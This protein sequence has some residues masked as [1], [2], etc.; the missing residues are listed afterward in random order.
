MSVLL[1]GS[2]TQN[3]IFAYAQNSWFVGIWLNPKDL[4]PQDIVFRL[5]DQPVFKKLFR[6][7]ELGLNPRIRIFLG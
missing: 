2:L 6:L 7:G 4:A 1:T 5:I 3:G